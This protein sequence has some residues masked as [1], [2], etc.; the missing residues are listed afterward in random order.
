VN[1]A[2]QAQTVDYRV[3]FPWT[4]ILPLEKQAVLPAPWQPSWIV[5]RRPVEDA[6]WQVFNLADAEQLND[7]LPELDGLIQEQLG[8]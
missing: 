5:A 6:F 3:N 4:H 8:R 1:T 7:I 2:W